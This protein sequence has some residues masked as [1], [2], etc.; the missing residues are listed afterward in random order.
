[1]AKISKN[2]IADKQTDVVEEVVVKE[3]VVIK[4]LTQVNSKSV[5]YH[6]DAS[7]NMFLKNYFAK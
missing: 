6:Q 2:K 4:D 3:P 7:M 5:V 1:M